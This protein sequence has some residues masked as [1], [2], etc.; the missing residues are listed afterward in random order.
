MNELKVITNTAKALCSLHGY[1]LKIMKQVP[2][3]LGGTSF[4]DCGT[5]QIVISKDVEYKNHATGKLEKYTYSDE[6][7]GFIILH[8]VGHLLQFTEK[9]GYEFSN[10]IE[11][12]DSD[13]IVDNCTDGKKTYK[14]EIMD[15][16]FKYFIHVEEDADYRARLLADALGVLKE[17]HTIELQHRAVYSKH[18]YLLKTGIWIHFPYQNKNLGLFALKYKNGRE[19]NKTFRKYFDSIVKEGPRT[20]IVRWENKTS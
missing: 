1:S 4:C 6:E 16:A 20:H 12:E 5:K 7:L 13:T 9:T 10:E 18:A 14:Q 17:S 8:E 11:G 3:K 2:D 19:L 15:E